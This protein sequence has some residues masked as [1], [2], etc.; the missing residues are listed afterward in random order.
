[1]LK[2]LVAR[3]NMS[4]SIEASAANF[5]KLWQCVQHDLRQGTSCRERFRQPDDAR[6]E[7]RGNKGAREYWVRNRWVQKFPEASPPKSR[8][9]NTPRFR[10]LKRRGTE[11][12]ASR[13]LGA[14]VTRRPRKLTARAAAQ[15]LMD[16]SQ[17]GLSGQPGNGAEFQELD[18]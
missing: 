15:P 16:V 14:P 6:K 18:L 9:P 3:R 8:R 1:M 5:H 7:P 13:A 17:S 2:V 12:E 4:A 11:E 10:T